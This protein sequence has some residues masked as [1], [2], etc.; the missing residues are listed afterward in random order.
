MSLMSTSPTFIWQNQHIFHPEISGFPKMDMPSISN[1]S[2]GRASGT[3]DSI[4][5]R[6][7]D[8]DEEADKAYG[9][10]Y[11]SVLQHLKH[12]FAVA[13]AISLCNIPSAKPGQ[14]LYL[15][16]FRIHVSTGDRS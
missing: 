10:V 7:D 4:D 2:I 9:G 16:P 3:F 11:K 8:K 13:K 6:K 15:L 5:F 1:D 12:R 14:A